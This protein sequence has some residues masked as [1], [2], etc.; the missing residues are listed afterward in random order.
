MKM[1]PLSLNDNMIIPENALKSKVF[2][3]P[4]ELEKIQVRF[5]QEHQ[6]EKQTYNSG[7]PNED[8]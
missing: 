2:L 7:N 3:S 8:L 6:S 5:N 1:K 4:T